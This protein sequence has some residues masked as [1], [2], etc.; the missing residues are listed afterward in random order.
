MLTKD[1]KDD[2]IVLT[3]EMMR[4]AERK[5]K[6]SELPDPEEIAE[7][8]ANILEYMSEDEVMAVQKENQASYESMIENKFPD[9]ANRYRA[10]FNLTI[11]G[12]NMDMLVMMLESLEKIKTGEKQ[13]E[14]VETELRDELAETYIFANLNDKEKKK[15]KKKMGMV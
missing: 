4:Q 1:P 6:P 11:S 9:F 15:L 5:L 3:D 12:E 10:I 14:K 7:T 13:M 8:V 2:G